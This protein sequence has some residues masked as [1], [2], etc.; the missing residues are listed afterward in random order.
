MR[1]DRPPDRE[2][3]YRAILD[4][5]IANLTALLPFVEAD[6]RLG[7]HAECQQYLFTPESIRAKLT[8]LRDQLH[9]L[10]SREIP[11]HPAGKSPDPA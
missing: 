2:A 5:E 10:I 1:C 6:P 7:F 9:P 11:R 3:R 8:D 4:A